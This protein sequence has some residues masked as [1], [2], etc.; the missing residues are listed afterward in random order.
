[1]CFDRNGRGTQTM[2]YDN[3]RRCTGPVAGRFEGQTLLIDDTADLPC[4]D[5]YRIL[6]RLARCERSNENRA[7][8]ESRNVRNPGAPGSRFTLRR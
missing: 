5:R 6:H 2:I 4:D 7:E 8:C 1:M 3:N